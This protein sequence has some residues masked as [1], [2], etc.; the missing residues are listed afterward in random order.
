MSG[1]TFSCIV[2]SCD[3]ET[4]RISN[5]MQSLDVFEPFKVLANVN[6]VDITRTSEPTSDNLVD[7]SN[8]LKTGYEGQGYRIVAIFFPG[9]VEG[10]WVD[11]KVKVI[12]DGKK[13]VMLRDVLKAY[14]FAGEYNG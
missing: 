11:N 13:W 6:V 2:V 5:M 9:K 7:I 1:V 14:N 3:K 12:S 8:A 4:L 10:S